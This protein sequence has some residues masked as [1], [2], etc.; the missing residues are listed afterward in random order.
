MPEDSP[1][2]GESMV[3]VSKPQSHHLILP[4]QIKKDISINLN[5]YLNIKKEIILKI[6][7]FF[8]ISLINCVSKKMSN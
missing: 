7:T 2:N 6:K 3:W 1:Q 8:K 4:P 5:K